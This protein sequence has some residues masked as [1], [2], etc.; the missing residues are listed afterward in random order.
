[1]APQRG[2]GVRTAHPPGRC[3]GGRGPFSRSATAG[4]R[5]L[6]NGRRSPSSRRRRR[7]E[8]SPWGCWRGELDYRSPLQSALFSTKL[9]RGTKPS[10]A[11]PP[12]M[13]SAGSPVASPARGRCRPH[14]PAEIWAE[15]GDDGDNSSAPPPPSF[16]NS[17]TPAAPGIG[18]K[19]SPP[20]LPQAI[21]LS[22]R[23]LCVNCGPGSSA[24]IWRPKTNWAC[25]R[26]CCISGRRYPDAYADR[27]EQLEA[28]G[29]LIDLE[30]TVQLLQLLA[31][32][33]SAWR[34]RCGNLPPSSAWS[35]RMRRPSKSGWCSKEAGSQRCQALVPL[36]S[37][38]RRHSRRGA[39]APPACSRDSSGFGMRR[40]LTNQHIRN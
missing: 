40:L 9:P 4:G 8:C 32:G 36:A 7:W 23:P 13:A 5:L 21:Q 6:Q 29:G 19:P 25:G 1:M 37:D 31:G 39:Q 22:R 20:G 28:V 33:E 26:L 14:L 15:M 16:G 24:A 2:A 18:K 10:V 30:Q 38:G 12:N 27:G 3:G 17:P 35:K 34:A 11:A